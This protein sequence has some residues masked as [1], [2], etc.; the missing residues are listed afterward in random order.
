M[1]K[2]KAVVIMVFGLG[3]IVYGVEVCASQPSELECARTLSNLGSVYY[4]QG[5]YRE[6]EPLF[7]RAIDMWSASGGQTKDLAIT[8][9]NLASVYQKRA[10]YPEAIRAYGRALELRQS[11]LGEDA[12]GLLPLLNGI[13][14]CHLEEGD[15]G[16]SE[17]AL[18]QALSII[19]SNHAENI[20]DAGDTFAAFGTLL[21]NQGDLRSAET[22]LKRALVVYQQTGRR[23]DEE[24]V[25]NNLGRVKLAQG[26]RKD[27]EQLFR[28]A[29]AKA[30]QPV[31]IENPD[32]SAGLINLANVLG[33]EHK[34]SKA[35]SLIDRAERIDRK[36]FAPD[37]IRLGSD[38]YN[39]G[40]LAFER[41]QYRTAEERFKECLAIFEKRLPRTHPELGRVTASLAEVYRK[42]GRFEESRALFSTA[43]QVLEKDWGPENPQL[44]TLLQSYSLVLRTR[45]EYAEA[46]S[47]DARAMRIR[48]TQA[49]K[50]DL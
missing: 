42:Q 1:R 17:Q 10:Q 14:A 43:L 39:S 34:F 48:V 36:N 5:R 44:L 50:S 24:T 29:I 28:E 41:K 27:A 18:R 32:V 20:A 38:A 2:S 13:G 46:E 7:I 11:M 22:W 40:L 21:K 26:S 25:L 31:G 33:A 6:A 47:L 37:D 16:Q 35:E 9:H 19:E 4:N 23:N 3:R 15:Y 49:L 45:Q 8:L 12:P 30:E